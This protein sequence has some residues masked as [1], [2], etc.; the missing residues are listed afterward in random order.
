MTI[1]L[2]WNI[3]TEAG[4]RRGRTIGKGIVVAFNTSGG[5]RLRIL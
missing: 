5:K 1:M 3:T 2:Q 4:R